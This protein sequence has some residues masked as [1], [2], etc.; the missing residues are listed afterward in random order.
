MNWRFEYLTAYVTHAFGSL[1]TYRTRKESMTLFSLSSTFLTPLCSYHYEKWCSSSVPKLWSP[2]YHLFYKN[3]LEIPVSSV[4]QICLVCIRPFPPPLSPILVSAA[5]ITG[6]VAAIAN[7]LL[8]LGRPPGSRH[9]S[10]T[11]GPPFHSPSQKVQWLPKSYHCQWGPVSLSLF[12]LV[13]ML[14]LKGPLFVPVTGSLHLLVP[15]PGCS[16]CTSSNTR[17]SS[18]SLK[19]LCKPSLEEPLPIPS[20]SIML[21]V[22][23]SLH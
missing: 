5:N 18:L 4:S 8:P 20:H 17:G 22:L 23:F 11:D 9:Y 10:K 7:S 2:L 3:H 14:W 13:T 12:S 15:C 1:M 16:S 21:H 6:L 19:S